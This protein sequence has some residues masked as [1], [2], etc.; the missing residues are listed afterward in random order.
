MA[1]EGAG[2]VGERV[3]EQ[4]RFANITI[5]E[6]NGASQF[7]IGVACA[8]IAEAILRDERVV[9]PVAAYRERYGV[10]IAL[11]TVVGAAGPGGVLVPAMTDEERAGFDGS[12]A[13]LREAVEGLGIS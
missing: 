3:E 2:E 9:L 7:G 11:P 8:Q 12:V 6:G 1:G 13:T 4:V 5:I 10:T